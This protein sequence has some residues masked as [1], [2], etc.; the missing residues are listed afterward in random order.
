MVF[1]SNIKSILPEVIIV[2]NGNHFDPNAQKFHHQW[3]RHKR[4]SSQV[5]G[6][7]E[8][9]LSTMI[10]RTNAKARRW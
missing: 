8:V 10:M 9:S 5:N 6:Q 1:L 3:T 4:T 2:S 7:T